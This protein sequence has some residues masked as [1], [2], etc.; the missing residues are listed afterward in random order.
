MEVVLLDKFGAAEA[1]DVGVY[2]AGA[3]LCLQAVGTLFGLGEG[4]GGGDADQ[5][6][7]AA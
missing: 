1:Q 4:T 3:Q 6:A 7:V 5:G 2:V